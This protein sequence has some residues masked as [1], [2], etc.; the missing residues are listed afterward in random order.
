MTGA[1]I[2]IGATYLF[3]L[4]KY[5]IAMQPRYYIIAIQHDQTKVYDLKFNH[6]L[7]E[8]K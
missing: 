3:W 1:Q 5:V 6:I 8:V 2:A 7:P 4:E